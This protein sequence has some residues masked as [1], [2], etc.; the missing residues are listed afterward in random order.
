MKAGLPMAKLSE[1]LF[2]IS[3]SVYMFSNTD[4]KTLFKR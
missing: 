2:V 4:A 3:K 1:Y